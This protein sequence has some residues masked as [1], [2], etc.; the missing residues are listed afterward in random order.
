M[1]QERICVVGCG[2][3]GDGVATGN[4]GGGKTCVL[5]MNPMECLTNQLLTSFMMDA[6]R[7]LDDGMGTAEDI[8]KACRLGLG[9]AVGP[10]ETMDLAGLDACL[11]AAQV[12]RDRT[13]DPR[14][15]P[16]P[17]VKKMVDAGWLGKKT[18]RGFYTY[19]ENGR[20]QSLTPDTLAACPPKSVR[21][22]GP[23]RREARDYLLS[24]S[25]PAAAPIGGASESPTEMR[26]GA[27]FNPRVC[28][29][30]T[31]TMGAGIAQVCAQSGLQVT[32]LARSQA[33]LE[34]GLRRV[35]G[36]LAALVKKGKMS[37]P[38][39]AE[40]L[41]RV[42]GV[43]EAKEAAD[44]GLF[45]EATYEDMGLKREVFAALDDVTD[46]AAVLSTT[47]SSLSVNEIAKSV[48]DPGRVVGLHFFNPAPVMKL[49]EVVRGLR[50][51]DST[52]EAAVSFTRKIGKDPV[53]CK[54]SPAFIVNRLLIP[55]LNQAAQAYDNGLASKE[56]M[57][58]A[59][60]LGLRYPL[61]L[62]K[63][64]DLIGLDIC[65]NMAQG[66]YEGHREPRFAPPPILK[67]MVKAGLLGRKSGQG[68][69]SYD[70]K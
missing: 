18:G 48:R 28:V 13:D 16:H 10:F 29:I 43:T 21:R 20:G 39:A 66:L 67:N 17:L 52:V 54:D 70:K 31:G 34:K 59:V 38:Q 35:E 11:A 26:R 68:F 55:M 12:L 15:A 5:G 41:G 23:D 47:T 42:R 58:T 19:S 27:G 24:P 37:Q 60:E 25:S 33:S 45:I 1:S 46:P 51:S 36:P 61:G 63:L 8:D 32:L 30:G 4:G 6:V 3:A 62:L 69:Y 65:C 49:V 57:D 14:Y 9:H 40:I 50:T 7:L 22:G 53:V 44:C 2:T 64:A 56:E